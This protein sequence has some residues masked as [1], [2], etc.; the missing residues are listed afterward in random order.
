M[1][2]ADRISANSQ[3]TRAALAPAERSSAAAALTDHRPAAAAQRAIIAGVHT[4]P[5]MVAQRRSLEAAFG[6]SA[7]LVAQRAAPEDEL[8]MK[9]APGVAQLASAGA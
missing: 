5:A 1:D 8:Q 6:A 7:Q 4:G 3:R 2:R 9:R